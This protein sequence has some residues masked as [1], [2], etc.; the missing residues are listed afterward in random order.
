MENCISLFFSEQRADGYAPVVLKK[1]E[2]W[3]CTAGNQPRPRLSLPAGPLTAPSVTTF[4]SSRPRS[5][6][7]PLV[8]WQPPFNWCNWEATRSSVASAISQP[9]P[10]PKA[11]PPSEA[12]PVML[13]HL[14]ASN[15]SNCSAEM[16]SVG[17]KRQ[18]EGAS[19][20][21][22]ASF[23]HFLSRDLW[24]FA[25]SSPPPPAGPLFL[26]LQR[27]RSA[28]PTCRQKKISQELPLT[29]T[30]ACGNPPHLVVSHSSEPPL[31]T[32]S[33]TLMRKRL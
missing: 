20:L 11:K 7:L 28:T 32:L 21:A 13:V 31:I 1:E 14:F 33:S 17:V 15:S 29:Q 8:W 23:L 5:V 18:T 19:R 27:C 9:P 6:F 10:H 4:Q 3:M 26:S 2:G 24:C 16:G 25:A 30:Q 22:I 12:A